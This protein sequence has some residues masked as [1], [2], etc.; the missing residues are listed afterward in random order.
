MQKSTEVPSV[1]F[2]IPRPYRHGQHT[3]ILAGDHPY[4]DGP[5]DSI[6]FLHQFYSGELIDLHDVLLFRTAEAI[7][8]AAY[9]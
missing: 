5:A 8:P 4:I 2:C 1:D 7:L 3:F 9:G 6:L